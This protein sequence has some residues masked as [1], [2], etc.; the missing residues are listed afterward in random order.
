MRGLLEHYCDLQLPEN[1]VFGLGAGLDCGYLA[2]PG[3]DPAAVVFGRTLS[4]EANLA[5]TL[6][7]DYEERPEPDDARAWQEVREEVLAGRPTMLSGDIFYLDYR[8]Y[9]VHVPGHRFVLLGFDDETEKVRIADRINAEPEVCSYGA[10][11]ASRNPPEG[12]STRNLWGRFRGNT[13]KND[14][15]TAS[16]LALAICSQRMLGEATDAMETL[17]GASVE[18]ASFGIAGIRRFAE[19]LPRWGAGDDAQ[20]RASYNGSVIEK[21][22]NGGGNFRRL[23][24][25]Y[26]EWAR[27]L[28]PET[29]PADVP[30]LAWKSAEQWTAVA[31]L[32]WSASDGSDT[33]QQ[34][35]ELVAEIAELE[36]ELFQR[37]A[38]ALPAGA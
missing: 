9:K 35:S 28:D 16:R 8:D 11:F 3:M 29:V 14:L 17:E 37:I 5:T 26:L 34:A 22:G 33:W 31:Q 25:G 15:H 18:A 6:G 27:E 13:V 7:V 38:S 21:F 24:A 12:L 2:L 36:Q 30:P 10:L 32:L 19:E 4:M 20:A 23:Y 1:V